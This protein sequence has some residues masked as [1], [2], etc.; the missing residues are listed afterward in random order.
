MFNT[1]VQKLNKSFSGSKSDTSES[2][3]SQKSESPEPQK[4]P[5]KPA[6]QKIQKKPKKPCNLCKGAGCCTLCDKDDD[7]CDLIYCANKAVRLHLVHLACDNL[8]QDLADLINNYY[9]PNCRLDEKFQISFYK[10]T[11]KSKQQEIT[12]I[13]KFRKNLPK[14]EN[15]VTL[16]SEIEK[17]FFSQVKKCDI[18]GKTIDG[19]NLEK[20]LETPVK[21]VGRHSRESAVINKAKRDESNN[22]D[23]SQD[24]VIVKNS[25][26]CVS[27][28]EELSNS[29]GSD[30]ESSDSDSV[31]N[32]SLQTETNEIHNSDE[33]KS[34]DGHNPSPQNVGSNS[35]LL[36]NSNLNESLSKNDSLSK[37]YSD[38]DNDSFQKMFPG[39]ESNKNFLDSPSKTKTSLTESK[40]N[41]SYPSSTAMDSSEKEKLTETIKLLAKKLSEQNDEKKELEKIIDEQTNEIRNL[42]KENDEKKDLKKIIQGQEE[43]IMVLQRD[44]LKEQIVL[45][46]AVTIVYKRETELKDTKKKLQIIEEQ[47]HELSKEINLN[48]NDKVSYD[49]YKVVVLLKKESN[50]SAKKTAQIN[51]LL[52]EIKTYR[53]NLKELKTENEHLRL[54]VVNLTEED[55]DKKILNF[56]I[57][58]NRRL[59]CK[60][61][62]QKERNILMGLEHKESIENVDS[63]LAENLML[64]EKLEKI[65]KTNDSLIL[66]GNLLNDGWET[67]SEAKTEDEQNST[68]KT[69][70]PNSEKTSSPHT[71]NKVEKLLIKVLEKLE[72]PKT[73]NMEKS[74]K[75]T[76]TA[77]QGNRDNTGPGPSHKKQTC[78]FFLQ[79]RCIFGDRCRND[80][81]KNIQQSRDYIPPWNTY[82]HQ[83]R[84]DSRNQEHR[85][86]SELGTNVNRGRHVGYWSYP[87]PPVPINETRFSHLNEVSLNDYNFPSLRN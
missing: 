68:T 9:C 37:S 81:P 6:S 31:S 80:H 42:Q 14:P 8:T 60:I 13:L 34:N 85:N 4:A 70:T 35:N 53:Q 54:K 19:L 25:Q 55:I 56:T 61:K 47:Y 71:D 11:S 33:V 62:I 49:P 17:N 24:N 22:K 40:L 63:I 73:H 32:K 12:E 58:E 74:N 78:K 46:E 30:S 23:V 77:A 20:T 52:N 39:Q 2:P 83:T 3:K 75:N 7:W 21:P 1:F 67:T 29:S 50:L 72:I 10:K 26:K 44:G 48:H 15:P 87:Q 65:E 76:D 45:D 18:S 84:L 79:Q 59:E 27:S 5:K 66:A 28:A 36:V 69:S 64:K 51:T 86:Y 82:P 38:D 43:E 57:E 41:D 16:T